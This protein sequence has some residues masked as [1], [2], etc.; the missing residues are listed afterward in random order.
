MNVFEGG[1]EEESIE[2]L[3][4]QV[5]EAE[6]VVAAAKEKVL[7]PPFLLFFPPFFPFFL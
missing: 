6:A 2:A 5:A 3:S 1:E 4:K 7:F